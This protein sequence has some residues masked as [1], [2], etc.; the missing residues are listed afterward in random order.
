M[1]LHERGKT[2]ILKGF[3]D[4]D[5]FWT[6]SILGVESFDKPSSVHE[7]QQR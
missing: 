1:H 3:R 6:V 5:G 2:I 4:P 7:L